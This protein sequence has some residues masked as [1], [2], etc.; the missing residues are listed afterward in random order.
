[1]SPVAACFVQNR[2]LQQIRC[3]YG[4]FSAFRVGQVNAL[5][6]IR[7]LH[8]GSDHRNRIR[9]AVKQSQFIEEGQVRVINCDV[10]QVIIQHPHAGQALALSADVVAVAGY[11]L[12]LVYVCTQFLHFRRHGQQDREGIV[13]G[14]HRC[15]IT[16]EHIII[17]RDDKGDITVIR[18]LYIHAAD[19]GFIR[20]KHAIFRVPLNQVVPVD[21]GTH[22]H[23]AGAVSPHIGEE[24]SGQRCCDSHRQFFIIICD[25]RRFLSGRFFSRFCQSGRNSCQCHHEYEQI[26]QQFLHFNRPP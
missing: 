14:G 24:V 25:L 21:H 1:M 13:P 11:V 22:V 26:C 23:I 17:Q 7:H 4:F 2:T 12:R 16:V 8:A 15:S 18:S 10:N 5:S 19:Y 6:V 20:N 9:R 3:K